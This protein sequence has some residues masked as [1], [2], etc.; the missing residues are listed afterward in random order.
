[1]DKWVM[2][3]AV[4]VVC[5]CGG[6][7]GW[8]GGMVSHGFAMNVLPTSGQSA[9]STRGRRDHKSGPVL[10]CSVLSCRFTAAVPPPC[11]SSAHGHQAIELS[12]SA[13]G[14]DFSEYNNELRRG[15]IDAYCGILQ[16]GEC[17]W[18]AGQRVLW[19]TAIVWPSC[20]CSTA[21][22]PPVNLYC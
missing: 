11:T 7:G 10:P 14:D 17:V 9:L 13:S 4:H 22:V 20:M 12:K 8:V 15:I 1:M 3:S 2:C 18:T 19:S 16:V 21:G 6:V 5:A